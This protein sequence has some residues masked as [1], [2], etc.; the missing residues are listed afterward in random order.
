MHPVDILG[1]SQHLAYEGAIGSVR[2][3]EDA[4]TG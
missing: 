1:E 3:H 4:R 2:Y